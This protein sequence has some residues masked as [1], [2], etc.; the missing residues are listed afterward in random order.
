MYYECTECDAMLDLV[1]AE[2]STVAR[3]CP[4]CETV[5]TWTYAFEGEGVRL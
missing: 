2:Q 4:N 5:T 1:G 3:E